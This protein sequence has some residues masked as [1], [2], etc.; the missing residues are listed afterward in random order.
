MQ[1]L[2]IVL[3]PVLAS[4]PALVLMPVFFVLAACVDPDVDSG[5]I[6]SLNVRFMNFS[7]ISTNV[8]YQKLIK[9]SLYL[10]YLA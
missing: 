7:V 8:R 10:L 4:V 6:I 2:V 3:I 9:G 1:V 5:I